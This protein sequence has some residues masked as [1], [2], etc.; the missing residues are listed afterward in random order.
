MLVVIAA[1]EERVLL[2]IPIFSMRYDA[3]VYMFFE[4]CFSWTCTYE[5]GK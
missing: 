3:D 1:L 4:S 5:A 2:L